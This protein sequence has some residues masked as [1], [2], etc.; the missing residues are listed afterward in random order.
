MQ[1]ETSSTCVGERFDAAVQLVLVELARR[2]PGRAV[3]VAE[4]EHRVAVER[5]DALVAGLDVRGGLEL[6][7]EARRIV[8]A[9][10]D[11]A[12]HAGGGEPLVGLLEPARERLQHHA[13]EPA[14]TLL[15]GQVG[16][17][18][19]L[20]RGRAVRVHAVA[21]DAP[22]QRRQLRL[23]RGALAAAKELSAEDAGRILDERDDHLARDIPAHHEH[24]RLVVLGRVQE[25]EPQH[26][27]AVD[28]ARVV[29]AEGGAAAAPLRLASPEDH[30]YS[31][32][33][34]R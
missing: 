31:G 17:L 21:A 29:Q 9:G 28:V 22:F 26:L 16:D 34:S 23:A 10:H 27:G 32:G 4:R 15:L 3:G 25:L 13:L 5:D 2:V 24:L 30:A 14:L 8:V 6:L 19:D 33:I 18:G 20:G 1:R 11:E 7:L 12:G